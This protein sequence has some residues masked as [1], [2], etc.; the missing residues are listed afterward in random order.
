M[1]AVV[2]SFNWHQTVKVFSHYY[3]NIVVSRPT[4][5]FNMLRLFSISCLL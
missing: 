3:R 1:A 4:D 2:D 5:F